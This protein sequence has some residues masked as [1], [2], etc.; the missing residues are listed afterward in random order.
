MKER[1]HLLTE[2]CYPG[3]ANLDQCSLEEI[4]RIINQADQQ[5]PLVVG[6]AIPAITRAAEIIW[7]QLAQGH[8]LFYLGAGTSGRLGVLDAAE[9][10]PTFS[11]D[12][13]MVQGIIAGGEKALQ[14]AIEGAEDDSE[15][16]ICDLQQRGFQKGDVLCGI[17]AGSTTPYVLAGLKYAHDL[18][19][20]TIFITCNPE[21]AQ[22][23]TVD[24][25]IVLP[26]GPEVLT[27]STRM[28]AGTA[29]KLV[30]NML[31]TA[32]MVKLGKV[33]GNLM[34][35]LR[36]TNQKLWDRGTRFVQYLTGL[37]REAAYQL[38]VQAQGQ[39]KTAVVMHHR[40]VSFEQAQQLLTAAQGYLRRVIG[41]VAIDGG[42]TTK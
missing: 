15:Q 1:G 32:V 20:P 39:V 5:V 17:A 21:G 19:S 28:K 40:G 35:D 4:L 41:D 25:V 22:L 29:T 9:C 27:G 10:P 34:V 11:T 8:R 33:Y 42:T 24:Q 7:Q 31:S 3:S 23:V 38:L 18:G 26:V 16:A 37:E 14:Q 36:A 2:Q 13:E 6:Q 12:P 30:L